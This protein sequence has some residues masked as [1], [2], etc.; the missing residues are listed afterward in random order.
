MSQEISKAKIFSGTG[1]GLS[2]K[3]ASTPDHTIDEV[4]HLEEKNKHKV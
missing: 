1:S 3:T 2:D 4:I